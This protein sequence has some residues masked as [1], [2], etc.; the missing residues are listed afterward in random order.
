MAIERRFIEENVKNATLDEFVANSV[1]RAGYVGMDI[2]RSPLGTR[3]VVKVER[4][5]RVIGRKGRSI[6]K[7]TAQLEE[8]FG[9]ENP[10]IEVEEVEKPQLNANVMAARIADQLERGINF[11]RVAYGTIRKVMEIGAVGVEI[12]ISGKLTGGRS[13]SVRFYD[14]YLKKCGQPALDFVSVGYATAKKKLGVLGVVVKIM[15][16]GV[17]L[18]DNIRFKKKEEEEEIEEESLKETQ[19]E[20]VEDGNP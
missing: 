10:Q 3:I 4:P 2:K 9:V 17:V 1:Q 16:P 18:P 13:R 12:V 19:K 11:R 6:K 15:P 8:E 7:L 20:E 14:G 5:G